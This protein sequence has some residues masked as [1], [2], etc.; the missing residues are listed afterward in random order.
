[1]KPEPKKQLK[2]LVRCALLILGIM[3]FI[4]AS[5]D[6]RAGGAGGGSSGRSSSGSSY[7]GGSSSSSGSSGGDLFFVFV[8]VEGLV[9]MVGFLYASLGPIPAT[10]ILLGAAVLFYLYL[11]YSKHKKTNTITRLS[12]ADARVSNPSSAAQK[13]GGLAALVKRN[14]NFDRDSFLKKV[15]TAFF[16]IQNAWME[17]NLKGVRRY[18]SDGV[19]QRFYTQFA[20]MELLGQKNTLSNIK[21]HQ[22]SI[23]KAEQDGPYD[24]I[25]VSIHASMLDRFVCQSYS[26]FNHEGYEDFVE[27]WSFIKRT[28]PSSGNGG[29]YNDNNCPHCGSPLPEDM[30][31]RGQCQYCNSIVNSGDYDWVL[32]EITQS[33]DY[34]EDGAARNAGLSAN[35]ASLRKKDPTF[36]VQMLE[37]KASNAYMQILRARCLAQPLVARRFVSDRIF[38]WLE[39]QSHKQ[40]DSNRTAYN[41]LYLNKV[42]LSGLRQKPDRDLLDFSLTASLQEISLE[43]SGKAKLR[44]PAVREESWILSLSRS[45]DFKAAK[46]SVFQHSCASCGAPIQD[47][48]DLSCPYCKHAYNSGKFEW[49]VDGFERP[50]QFRQ[51]LKQEAFEQSTETA[52]IKTISSFD[53]LRYDKLYD[54][55]DYALTNLMVMSMADGIFSPEEREACLKIG[56]QLGYSTESMEALIRLATGGKLR[57]KMPHDTSKR[58]KIISMMEDIASIDGQISQEEQAILDY[59]RSNYLTVLKF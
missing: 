13:A 10:L 53:P 35:V 59:V 11:R 43:S 52:K 47:S 15:E 50:G 22:M 18:I 14:P 27:Y 5:L 7:S 33:I 31:E 28:G 45:S 6:A 20:M 2:H 16:G 30:G 56:K 24:V 49:T 17:Q 21:I 37:D 48:L 8:I 39:E 26:A 42:T 36:S 34:V 55:R 12:K 29:L 3:L 32:A 4:T 38:S 51:A 46:G 25:H 1:M 44:D 9:R 58:Q 40:K 19:Y 23:D 54:V 57:I 41:R